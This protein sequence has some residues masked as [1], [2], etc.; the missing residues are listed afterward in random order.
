MGVFVRAAEVIQP[1]GHDESAR[2]VREW[3]DSA[4]LFRDEPC[5]F[6]ELAEIGGHV[7]GVVPALTLAVRA[8][9]L[10]QVDGVEGV[11]L[12]RE[13]LG[14]MCLEEI[15][16]HPVHPQQCR[17]SRLRFAGGFD[18]YRVILPL[19]LRVR[20]QVEDCVLEPAAELIGGPVE[21]VDSRG[22]L[23]V[24]VRLG[25]HG[26]HLRLPVEAAAGVR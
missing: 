18:E 11:A 19:A 6:R 15:V 5:G 24:L 13:M 1:Q 7:V 17:L 3:N 16:R 8:T 23:C 20:S 26:L 14:D 12:R 25:S 21:C 2:R 9:A 22:V 10:V 4:V